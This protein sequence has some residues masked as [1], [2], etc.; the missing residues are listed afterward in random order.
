[1][2]PVVLTR[3]QR[4]RRR[5]RRRRIDNLTAYN[6]ALLA[7]MGDYLCKGKTLK[8]SDFIA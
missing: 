3:L 4:R 7:T 1:M 6:E 5:K 2:C 8:A